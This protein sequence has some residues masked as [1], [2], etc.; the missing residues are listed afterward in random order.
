MPP[1]T[2]MLPT[3]G[4]LFVTDAQGNQIAQIP[5]SWITRINTMMADNTGSGT[6]GT[7][8]DS[9]EVGAGII[10]ALNI[11]G[12]LEDVDRYQRRLDDAQQARADYLNAATTTSIDPKKLEKLLED[13]DRAQENLDDAQTDALSN[14]VDAMWV[15]VFGAG[16]RALGRINGDSMMQSILGGGGSTNW[17]ELL[18]AGGIGALLVSAFSRGRRRGRRRR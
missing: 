9:V 6:M 2:F 18:A 17:L 10:E 1:Q 3:G 4:N 11:R 12:R 7:F 5:S 13:C 16:A 15:Q 14:I 8:G